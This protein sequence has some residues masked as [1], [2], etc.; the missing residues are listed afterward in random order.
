MPPLDGPGLSAPFPPC[1]DAGAPD[2]MSS[3]SSDETGLSADATSPASR[4]N[5]LTLG[6]MA[7]VVPDGAT[8]RESA[9]AVSRKR[10]SLDYDADE[11]ED[12]KEPAKKA[13]L[14]NGD[15]SQDVS[16]TVPVD[17]SLIRREIWQHV[18]TFCP[19]KTLGH[20]L[21]VNKSFNLHLDPSSDHEVHGSEKHGALG[22]LKPNTIWQV[23]RRLFWPQM[24]TPLRSKSELEMWRL[25]CSPKCQYCN[26]KDDRRSSSSIE[27]PPPGPGPDGVA[28]IWPFAIRTCAPCLLRETMKELDLLV[29]PDI[30]SAIQDALPHVYLTREL[31]ILHSPSADQGQLPADI[32]ATKLFLRDD[33]E[34]LTG[35]FATARGMGSG[36]VEE[37]LKG[38]SGQGKETR[39]DASK[40]EKWEASGGVAKMRSQ[41]YPGWEETSSP[42]MNDPQPAAQAHAAPR[43]LPA[44]PSL[45]RLPPAPFPQGRQERTAEEAAGLKAARKAEI[46]RRAMLLDPPLTADI[47]RHMTS[48]KAATQII[49]PLDDNAWEL[50]KPRLIAQRAEAEHLE[51][52]MNPSIKVLDGP[53]EGERRLE[54]TLATTKDARDLIDK[55][56]EEVQAPLRA[57]ISGLADDLIRTGWEGGKKLTKASCSKFAC[58]VLANVRKRFYADIAQDVAAAKAQGRTPP[59][60]PPEGP[61]TQKLTLENMK[62]LFD[63]KIKPH[64]ETIRKELFYCSGCEAN[65]KTFGFEGAIQH[66]AAKH[67]TALSQ[68]SVVVHWRAEWPEALPFSPEARL[69][70]PQ[71]CRPM[72]GP[73]PLGSAPPSGYGYPLVPGRPL[74]GPYPPHSA[75]GSN[76]YPDSYQQPP[77]QPFPPPAT[78]SVPAPPPAYGQPQQYPQPGLYPPYQP[79]SAQYH[80]SPIDPVP[81]FNPPPPGGYAP[82]YP[83]FQPSA[84]PPVY[85]APGPPAPANNYQTKL[86]FV[87]ILSRQIWQSLGNIKDLPGSVRVFVTLHH[88]AER[89]RS[90]FFEALPLSLFIDGLSDHKDMRPVR[91]VNGLICKACTLGLGNGPVEDDRKSFSLPQLVKHFQ[92][93]HIEPMQ[94]YNAPLLDWVVDMVFLADNATLGDQRSFLSEAQRSLLTDAIP[95]IFQPPIGPVISGHGSLPGPPRHHDTRNG[96]TVTHAGS[97]GMSHGSASQPRSLGDPSS[98]N[99]TPIGYTPF[100]PP[101][102]PP[103]PDTS[104]R[105]PGQNGQ[106]S[107]AAYEQGYPDSRGANGPASGADT[108][109]N[110][111]QSP[112]GVKRG[113]NSHQLDRKASKKNKRGRGK[114]GPGVSGH[115]QFQEGS[116][117]LMDDSRPDG[118]ENRSTWKIAE[119]RSGQAEH[120]GGSPY[121][122]ASNGSRVVPL[123]S[124]IPP[125]QKPDKPDL[126][127]ALEMRLDERMPAEVGGHRMPQH[128]RADSRHTPMAADMRSFSRSNMPCGPD[129][130]RSRSPTRAPQYPVYDTQPGNYATRCEDL[131]GPSHEFDHRRFDEPPA[132][133]LYEGQH[134][135][136]LPEHYRYADEPYREPRQNVRAYEIVQVIDEDGK[137][138]F[139]RR[140]VRDAPEQRYIRREEEPYPPR[141]PVYVGAPRQNRA[142]TRQDPT[143][144]DEYDPKHPGA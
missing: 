65:F 101:S 46:E 37:W 110:G 20:L 49:A 26:K 103:R 58:D 140:P 111:K 117:P 104:V 3:H 95:N 17:R 141:E 137:E 6:V 21:R 143:Y 45:P 43:N 38:L 84:P 18:F 130:A 98:A 2:K 120:Q 75:F 87:A 99:H 121:Q 41:L 13:K 100:Q 25:A 72:P 76:P 125:W 89:F 116:A 86:E 96:N 28:V 66:Y 29:S 39:H 8:S 1:D 144:Y 12:T 139:Y 106:S 80:N 109:R 124:S 32:Q 5:Q 88:L 135:E 142:D 128:H 122:Q 23:S 138:S 102:L 34:K 127:S 7:A 19:P 30:P 71:I 119:S 48:F 27:T 33:V 15:G 36:A 83:P 107:Y 50:L 129:R 61:F 56:W 68:G 123:Q 132:Q 78:F 93:K 82:G 67:T 79:P 92:T 90:R 31:N 44:N 53:V 81:A 60:D 63:T 57:K 35:D 59:S 126:L 136:S 114:Q 69:P 64:T 118:H 112:R 16:S 9:L 105:Q 52:S 77:P 10:K 97:R 134:Q 40:W 133:A 62:W 14:A 74:T 22:P 73:F 94:A 51:K 70:K 115:R 131:D 108:P 11:T 42:L 91:N 47:L 85:P 24:P 113:R 55:K 4:D 54:T